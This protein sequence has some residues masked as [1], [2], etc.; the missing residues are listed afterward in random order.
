[1]TTNTPTPEIEIRELD[2]RTSDGVDVRLLWNSQTDRVS[3]L[4][5]DERSGE[6]F[7]V[8]IDSADAL[9]AFWHPYTY[10]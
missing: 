9:A 8:E 2:R 10:A 4:V 7:E 1:M 3:V 6:S 5:Q